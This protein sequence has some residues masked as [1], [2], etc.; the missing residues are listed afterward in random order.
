[1]AYVPVRDIYDMGSFTTSLA[2]QKIQIPLLP[3]DVDHSFIQLSR[4]LSTSEF[5]DTVAVV[6]DTME[7]D[8]LD[9]TSVLDDTI[10]LVSDDSEDTVEGNEDT[11]DE[12]ILIPSSSPRVFIRRG[13]VPM[14][15]GNGPKSPYESLC[16]IHPPLKPKHSSSSPHV[17]DM[18]SEKEHP[19]PVVALLTTTQ[20]KG[21]DPPACDIVDMKP[22]KGTGAVEMLPG[23][24]MLEKVE[25]TLHH[26]APGI[27]VPHTEGLK[28]SFIAAGEF[29]KR[30]GMGGSQFCR[31]LEV[32]GTLLGGRAGERS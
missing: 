1:L 3:E 20:D 16:E 19:A 2:V 21:S 12:Y 30:D 8:S 15:R 11:D 29:M 24:K 5:E 25:G 9:D 7:E 27:W 10:S 32:W 6:E 31:S 23:Q 18:I 14:Q 26:V 17:I 28:E 22:D 13:S 4:S